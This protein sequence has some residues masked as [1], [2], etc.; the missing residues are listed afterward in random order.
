[1]KIGIITGIHE[2]IYAL[3]RSIAMLKKNN[4]Q[5]LVCLGDILGYAEHIYS[6]FDYR[7]ADASIELVVEKCDHIV[8]GNHD[9]FAVK[10]IPFY[11]AGFDYPNNDL[12]MFF[13]Q[14]QSDCLQSP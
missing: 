11:N 5:T 2:D 10:K 1:M 9:Y 7:D 6:F 14:C 8:A 12:N 4:C 3:T 13:I